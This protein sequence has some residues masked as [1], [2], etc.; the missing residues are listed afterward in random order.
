MSVTLGPSNRLALTHAEH[1]Q[2][3]PMRSIRGRTDPH[4]LT[5]EGTA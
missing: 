5:D 2:P 1:I 3:T 4:S